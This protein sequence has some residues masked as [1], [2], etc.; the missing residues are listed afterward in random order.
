MSRSTD[1]NMVVPLARSGGTLMTL[2]A[3]VQYALFLP[4]LTL[5]V[6]PL[7][8]YGPGISG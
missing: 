7:G 3:V 2:Q 8:G 4:L 6:K 5:L 1:Y